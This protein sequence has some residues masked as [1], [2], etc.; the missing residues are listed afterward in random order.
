MPNVMQ[1]RTTLETFNPDLPR[2]GGG[3]VL[4][5]VAEDGSLDCVDV[6]DVS[7]I[8]NHF[9]MLCSLDGI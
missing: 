4:V 2:L 6:P 9:L 1:P 7:H 3:D 8:R 5:L